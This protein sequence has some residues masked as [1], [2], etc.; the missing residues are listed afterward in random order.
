MRSLLLAGGRSSRMGQDKA[1]IEIGGFSMIERAANALAAANLEPIRIAVAEPE[2]VE[3]YGSAIGTG[4]DL[5]WVLD[6]MT[7]AGP[8]DAIEEALLDPKCEDGVLQLATVDYPWVSSDLFISLQE[9]LGEDDS[10]IM[11]HDGNRGHPLLS[12]IRTKEVLKII[13]GDRRPL[14]VQ[15]AEARHSILIEDPAVLLNVNTPEDLQ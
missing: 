11:P 5:E 12:L 13:E 14:R 6:S 7:F 8:I 4:L 15:F 3:E 10:L 2:D 9:R 1:L